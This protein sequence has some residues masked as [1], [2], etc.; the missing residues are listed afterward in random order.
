[1]SS[2]GELLILEVYLAG[3]KAVVTRDYEAAVNTFSSV[4]DHLDQFECAQNID[5]I[6]K[7]LSNR[8]LCHTKLRNDSA[9]IED[10]SNLLDRIEIYRFLFQN[11]DQ[12]L[13]QSV[14]IES[15]VNLELKTLMRRAVCYENIGEYRKAK[16]DL[17]TIKLNHSDYFSRTLSLQSQWIRL[18][19][20]LEQDRV[21]AKIDGRPAWM[22]H[23]HQSLRLSL[24]RALPRQLRLKQP[25]TCRVALGNELG[26]FDRSMFSKLHEDQSESNLARSLGTI[27]CEV[28]ALDHTLSQ[29]LPP[30]ITLLQDQNVQSNCVQIGD[31]G[32]V[33]CQLLLNFPLIFIYLLL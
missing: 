33:R 6:V 12:E 17:D 9:A 7:I 29:N 22:A 5:S 4:A 31:D 11:I 28:F 26:L 1:M 10:F 30:L 20:T 25:F 13:A 27:R 2:A 21:A 32:K 19:H 8:G 15:W 14:I 24:I 18:G 16:I 3:S 23:A